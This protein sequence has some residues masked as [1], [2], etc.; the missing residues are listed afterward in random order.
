MTNDDAIAILQGVAIYLMSGNKISYSDKLMIVIDMA[1]EAL[2]A[3]DVTETNVGDMISRQA[4]IDALES[5]ERQRVAQKGRYAFGNDEFSLEDAYHD[6]KF[7]FDGITDDDSFQ[8]DDTGLILYYANEIIY[9]LH[10]ALEGVELKQPKNGS[11]QF[12]NTEEL[13]DRTMDDL[14]S[15][16]DAIDA[17]SD[18]LKRV[19][20]EYKDI[21][22][23]LIGKLPSVQ[24]EIG[25]SLYRYKCFITDAEG[26]QHEVVHVGDIR[27]VTG[28]EI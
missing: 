16:Q 10:K 20:V 7:V 14:V 15:R 26:L 24:P 18:G 23:K 1:I 19:F 6:C 27:R 28:W 17:V 11:E 8:E 4:E 12:G 9:A 21:A 2:K 5:Q 22:E 13:G 3:Q 25:E